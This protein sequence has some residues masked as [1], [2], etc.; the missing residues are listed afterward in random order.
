MRAR[1]VHP[2]LPRHPVLRALAIIGAAVVLTA[3]V[4]TGLVIGAFALAAAALV[5]AVRR[6]LSRRTPRTAADP[7]VIEGEFTVVPPRPRASLPHPE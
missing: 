4:A 1:F 5:L 6:W 2:P 3:L 7:S